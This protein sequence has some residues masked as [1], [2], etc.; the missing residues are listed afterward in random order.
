[1]THTGLSLKLEPNDTS[2]LNNFVFSI[3]RFKI[4]DM[5]TERSDYDLGG[6]NR[7]INK[8]TP[9]VK[10]DCPVSVKFVYIDHRILQ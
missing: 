5:E 9:F 8:D 3:A 10:A 6:H 2:K 4:D 7:V 1:M